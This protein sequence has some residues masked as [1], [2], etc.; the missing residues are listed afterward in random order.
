VS[1]QASLLLAERTEARARGE[2]DARTGDEAVRPAHAEVLAERSGIA[3]LQQALRL[4]LTS[5]GSRLHR[6]RALAG[7][8]APARAAL[9][10]GQI[11]F[12]HV[13]VLLEHTEGL[14]ETLVGRMQARCLPRAAI[15]TPGNFGKSLTRALHALDPKG[16]AQ[17]HRA[18]RASAGVRVSDAQDGMSALVITAT[19]PDA[20]W[21]Y[22]ILDTLARAELHRQRRSTTTATDVN[23]VP[24]TPPPESSAAPNPNGALTTPPLLQQS[25]TSPDESGVLGTPPGT[26]GDQDGNGSLGT[27]PGAGGDQDRNGSTGTPSEMVAAPEGDGVLGTPPSCPQRPP[28]LDQLRSQVFF[29]LLARA[30]HDPA[31]PTEHGKR[32]IETQIVITLPALLGLRDDPATINGQSVPAPIARE[33]ATGTTALRRLVTDPVTGHLLDYGHRYQPPP[34]LTEYLIARDVVCRVPHCNIRASATDL[35]HA[36]PATKGGRTSSAN[37]GAL[38]R[39]HHSPKTAGLTDLIESHAD[40]SATYVT[41]LGQRIHIPPR[42]VLEHLEPDPPEAERSTEQSECGPPPF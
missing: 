33:L 13:L 17:A 2:L 22:T 29:D 42:P 9:L 14:P 26:S 6:A 11:N 40:G 15:Q 19:S 31:F 20:A 28:S 24:T 37:M 4:S 18:A 35:D 25:A 38:S 1:L 34:D 23:G 39:G 36:R 16:S 41:A 10:A 27:P 3:E 8:L 5:A 30:V 12:G 7:R 32:R 21:G